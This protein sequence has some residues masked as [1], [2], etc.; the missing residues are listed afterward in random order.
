MINI[1]DLTH[2]STPYHTVIIK[3]RDC[4]G[5]CCANGAG[6]GDIQQRRCGHRM[7]LANDNIKKTFIQLLDS[8]TAY[9]N[10]SVNKTR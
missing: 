6:P 10:R 8:E 4:W 9:F 5:D 2:R 1:I 7:D 3:I